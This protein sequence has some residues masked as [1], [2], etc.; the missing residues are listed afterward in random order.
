MTG[1][2]DHRIEPLLRALPDTL[3]T[4]QVHLVER[5]YTVAA[6]WHRDQKRRGGEAYITHPVA[7]AAILAE[8]G[9]G[10]EMVCAALL[11]D[12]LEDT[13]CTEAELAAEFGDQITS[14]LTGLRALHDSGCLQT[15]TDERVLTLKLVDR[16]HN[17]RTLGFLPP[18]RQR[19]AS[20][21]TLEVFA[22]LAAQLGLDRIRRELET[23]A[24]TRLASSGQAGVELSFHAL[25]AGSVLLPPQ[26]RARWLEEWLS[27]LQSLPDRRTRTLFAAQLL[28]GMP[29]LAATLRWPTTGLQQLAVSRT[30]RAVRWVLRSNARTWALLTPLVAWMTIETAVSNPGDAVAI[31]ITV[32]PVLGAGVE[33]VRGRLRVPDQRKD[34]A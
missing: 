10:H 11:H 1:R 17:Q 12:V 3:T 14:M 15:C 32:P 8:L 13:T 25:T 2:A 20:Q 23:L 22:P 21:E 19:S 26:A 16:L 31:L 4:Q 7:V 33:A 18:D 28:V 29:R 9:S 24:R 5:A 27:D 34:D 6:Y 30:L